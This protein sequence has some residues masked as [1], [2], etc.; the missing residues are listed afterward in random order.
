MRIL[1]LIQGAYGERKVKN[2]REH[3]PKEWTVEVLEVPKALPPIIDEPEEFLP[4][5]LPQVDLLLALGESPGAAQLIPAAARLSGAR[6]VLAP[7]DNRNWLPQ[8][9]K[10]QL[11]QELKDMGL[12]AVFPKPFCSLTENSSGYGRSAQPYEDEIIAAFARHFGKPELE[13]TVDPETRKIKRV[14]VLRDSA[15]GA[16]RSVAK[17]LEGVSVEEAEFEAGMLH[18]HYPCLASMEREWIDDRLFDTLMHVSGYII[19]EE[20]ARQVKPFK[21]ALYITPGERVEDKKGHV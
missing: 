12:G 1:A 14:R 21:K 19:K 20:V 4:P 8:G 13:I 6:A 5:S 11:E 18:H 17:G 10:N 3:G 9:L 7:I 15:C 16:A 2:L